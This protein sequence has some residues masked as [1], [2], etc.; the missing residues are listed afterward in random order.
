MCRGCFR[1]ATVISRRTGSAWSASRRPIR[2]FRSL[3]AGFV[4]TLFLFLQS[5]YVVTSTGRLHVTDEASAFFQAR[6]LVEAGS[7][8]VPSST[9]GFTFYGER[10]RQGR[11]R[12][13][14]GPLHALALVPYYLL[15]TLMARTPGVTE[16]SRDLVLSFAVV[17]S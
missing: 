2:S 12:A 16:H 10:D 17:L 7:L 13:P 8:T 6:E 15:G 5:L 4:W 14:N 9:A 3:R 11:L 1:S